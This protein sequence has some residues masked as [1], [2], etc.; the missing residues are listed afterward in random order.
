MALYRWDMAKNDTLIRERGISFEEIVAQLEQGR[1]L[2]ILDHPNRKR[3][4]HQK[5]FVV[6]I[7]GY[8]Y[9]VPFVEQGD[10]IFLKTVIPSRK[11]TRRYLS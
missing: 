10:E 9:A 2:A 3:Y 11:L 8:A 1:W 4:G 6:E 7:V 5:V